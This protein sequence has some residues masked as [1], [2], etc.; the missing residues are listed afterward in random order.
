[1]RAWGGITLYDRTR[2][3]FGRVAEAYS[4][5]A[6]FSQGEDLDWLVAAA[7]PRPDETAL[8]LGTAAGYTAFAL[9]PHVRRVVGIDITPA[10]I[11]VARRNALDR[12]LSNFEGIVANA[13]ELPFSDASFDIV[14]CRYTAHHFH[15]PQ[16]VMLEVA[17][18]LRPG[19]RLVVVDNT[20]PDDPALDRWIN[21]VE[22]LRDPSH[23]K[24][25]SGTEWERL[26]TGA[27]LTYEVVR[28]WLLPL[29]L[30]DWTAR[31]QTPPERVAELRV[32][33][34]QAGPEARRVF[35]IA[36][37]GSRFALPTRLMRGVKAEG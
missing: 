27:G 32:L 7:A 21:T 23:V 15:H 6:L 9:A 17:R 34:A 22:K 10:M 13:E 36:A 19:G 14:A 28:T 12:G 20:A 35:A 1:S 33:L 18:V 31:Q 4:R 3:Q 11:Q 30:E 25:W 2:E 29:E 5:S 24:Q 37:D 16:R 26:F 8:D